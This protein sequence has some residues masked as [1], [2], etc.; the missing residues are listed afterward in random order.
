RMKEA[1]Y[2]RFGSSIELE[3]RVALD[4]E[5]VGVAGLSKQNL[6]AAM[7]NH[8]L[9]EGQVMPLPAREEMGPVRARMCGDAIA[10]RSPHVPGVAERPPSGLRPDAET[11][12][13]P[14]DRNAVRES[15]AAGV[16]HVYLVVVASRHP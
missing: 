1:Q 9:A 11:V 15:A 7:K 8:V 4:V 5:S 14:A 6:V 13:F 2:W 16:E 10:E 12:G 3:H